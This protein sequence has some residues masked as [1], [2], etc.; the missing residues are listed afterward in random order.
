MPGDSFVHDILLLMINLSQLRDQEKAIAVFTEAV[1]GQGLGFG[2]AWRPEGGA[3]PERCIPIRTLRSRF[4]EM[5]ILG[6]AGGLSGENGATVRNA[7]SMLAIILEN[8]KHGKSLEGERDR[9]ADEVLE[10]RAE[11]RLSEVKFESLVETMNDGLAVRD[12]AGRI[13]YANIKMARMLGMAAAELVGR[14]VEEFLEGEPAAFSLGAGECAVRRQDGGLT[15]AIVSVQALPGPAA[16]GA[17][18]FALFTDISERKQA[19]A[20][21]SSERERLSVTLRSIGE[22][23]ISCDSEGR[24]TIMNRAAE[25]ITGWQAAE[26]VG[27]PVSAVLVALDGNNGQALESPALRAMAEGA[28][29]TSGN[30][31]EL[32]RKDGQRISITGSSSPIRDRSGQIV[33][34]VLVFRD[35]TEKRRTEEALRQTQRLESLGVLAGGIAHDFNNLLGGVFGYLDLA[36][37]AMEGGRSADYL[38]KALSVFERAKSLTQQLLTF[39]KGGEPVRRTQDLRPLIANC[40]RF[41]LSGT[42]VDCRLVLDEGLWPADI[43]ENQ[44]GQVLDNLLIN[45]RQ[46][47]PEGGTATIRAE[48]GPDGPGGRTVLIS[49]ADTGVGIPKEILPKIFD[50]FFTT[51]RTGNGLGLAMAYSI[52]QKHGGSIAAASEPG[53]GTVFSLSLPASGGSSGRDASGEAARF[54]G[55]GS[56]LVMDDEPF[57]RDI[58]RDMLEDLG[59][60]ADCVSDAREALRMVSEAR[61]KGGYRAIFL[62]LTIP[63]G[64]GGRD[65]VQALREGGTD[66]VIVASSGYSEDPIMSRPREFGFDASIRKPFRAQDLS[67]LFSAVMRGPAIGGSPLP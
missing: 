30:A 12:G 18:D 29:V 67:R 56:V 26:A 33:G 65:I 42:N 45:A 44:I 8:I 25:L 35:E 7:V 38:D 54:K 58:A 53:Q 37:S 21:L 63:G 2:V 40:A 9:L 31:A 61:G 55:S 39:A 4:G 22:G 36:R 27:L 46:A 1:N 34:A 32:L 28:I 43:D 41:A 52:V 19:E 23:V 62:D 50:P 66:A 48:N 64:P 49:V 57:I 11:L 13:M 51:K 15:H 5:E 47:M 10:R 3:P 60:C 17:G 16:A 6:G 24:V 20:V 14:R 59:F